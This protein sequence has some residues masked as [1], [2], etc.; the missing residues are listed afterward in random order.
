MC[1]QD[2]KYILL[3]FKLAFPVTIV[4]FAVTLWLESEYGSVVPT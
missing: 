4:S 2:N 1:Y 3:F